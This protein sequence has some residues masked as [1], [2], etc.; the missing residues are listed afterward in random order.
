[1][2][3]NPLPLIAL[4]LLL[5]PSLYPSEDPVKETQPKTHTSGGATLQYRE[6]RADTKEAI[7]W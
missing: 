1:M 5:T 4:S 6:Y 2:R 3:T 7:P